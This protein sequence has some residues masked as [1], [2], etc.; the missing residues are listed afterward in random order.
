VSIRSNDK[1]NVILIVM[2]ATRTD[3]LSCY[4]YYRET[5]PNLEALADEGVL[6]ENAMSAAPWTLPSI[7]S[8]FTGTYPCR[9]GNQTWHS[10]MDDSLLTLAQILANQGYSTAAFHTAGYIGPSWGTS[11]GLQQIRER[12]FRGRNLVEL[13]EHA[14]VRVRDILTNNNDCGASWINNQVQA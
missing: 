6:F 13:L 5:A 9:H 1:P 2:D 14:V 4:G 8:M 12:L 10:V 11:E 7:T 3:H